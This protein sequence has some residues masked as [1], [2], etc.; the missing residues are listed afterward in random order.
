MP[1]VVIPA[2]YTVVPEWFVWFTIATMMI[3]S[4]MGTYAVYQ[5]WS[6]K[7][8]SP[9]GLVFEY[10]RKHGLD[11]L[12]E[13]L[14]N[15]RCM[16]KVGEREKVKENMKPPN[17]YKGGEFKFIPETKTKIVEHS[18]R[19]LPIV[20]YVPPHPG[21]VNPMGVRAMEQLAEEYPELSVES[22]KR[23]IAYM[24][25]TL[26]EEEIETDRHF[27]IEE[28]PH[29]WEKV[30]TIKAEIMGNE[31]EGKQGMII[32]EGEM[33]F[34]NIADVVLSPETA[35][36]ESN[37]KATIEANTRQEMLNKSQDILLYGMMGMMLMIGAGMAIYILSMV[38]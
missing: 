32:R 18:I 16:W 6:F 12:V 22:D 10:A 31:E 33:V 28:N 38:V 3:A 36:S 14:P 8:F 21:A 37:M 29:L 26:P 4:I 27:M 24:F 35:A 9:E 34:Q 23:E 17:W 25:L 1:T 19:G 15:M 11:V 5:R 30:K 7:K 20:H 13:H 2:G